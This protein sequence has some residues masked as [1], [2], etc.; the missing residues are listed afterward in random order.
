VTDL[1]RVTAEPLG[2]RHAVQPAVS[3]PSEHLAQENL[4]E[5]FMPSSHSA[6]MIHGAI[7]SSEE[8]WGTAHGVHPKP[9]IES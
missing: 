1:T 9:G 5:S 6:V 2:V 7:K 8:H 3:A 4:C